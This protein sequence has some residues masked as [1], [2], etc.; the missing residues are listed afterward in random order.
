M[1][2]HANAVRL[3]SINKLFSCTAS[4]RHFCHL[5]QGTWSS[6]EHELL[7]LLHGS[8]DLKVLRLID[9]E[10]ASEVCWMRSQQPRDDRRIG[11]KIRF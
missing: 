4:E 9:A 5:I 6:R 3:E 8:L 7:D 10:E 2:S 1:P 11:N